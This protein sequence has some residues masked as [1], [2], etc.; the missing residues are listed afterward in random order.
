MMASQQNFSRAFIRRQSDIMKQFL[1]KYQELADYYQEQFTEDMPRNTALERLRTCRRMCDMILRRLSP[2]E[3]IFSSISRIRQNCLC[4]ETC[5]ERFIRKDQQTP[6]IKNRI[7]RL[8]SSLK[9]YLYTMQRTPQG[10]QE[11]D[12]NEVQKVVEKFMACLVQNQQLRRDGADTTSSW[13]YIATTAGFSEAGSTLEEESQLGDH[14]QVVYSY[15]DEDQSTPGSESSTEQQHLARKEGKFQ[16]WTSIHR[17]RPRTVTVIECVEA[18]KR[19]IQA[20]EPQPGSPTIGELIRAS[21]MENIMKLIRPLDAPEV[22]GQ[23]EYGSSV[24]SEA[25]DCNDYFAITK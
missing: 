23:S 12:L 3:K 17:P 7:T 6:L 8:E 15:L 5:C 20:R 11:E 18:W 9:P 25:E 16:P 13:S 19:A 21:E 4:E 1:A 24:S 22:D 2:E 10:Q 14:Y